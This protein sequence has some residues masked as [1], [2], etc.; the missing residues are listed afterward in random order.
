MKKTHLWYEMFASCSCILFF[1]FSMSGTLL[2][3]FQ[4]SE[5]LVIFLV[6]AMGDIESRAL[7]ALVIVSLRLDS[8]RI[9]FK[10]TPAPP[11]FYLTS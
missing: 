1:M 8:I 6:Q 3:A 4:W 9:I 10:I 11:I 5:L 2:E 7:L